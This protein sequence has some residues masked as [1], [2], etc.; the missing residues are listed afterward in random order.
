MSEPPLQQA[1]EY[2]RSLISP[3]ASFLIL[4]RVVSNLGD[5][6]YLFAIPWLVF[7]LTKSAWD[8]S[9]M[10]VLDGLPY[11]F[12]GAVAG[13]LADTVSKRALLMVCVI[14]QALLVCLLPLSFWLHMNDLWIVFM[15]GLLTSSFGFTFSVTYESLIPIMSHSDS[16]TAVT[17]R[18]K[19]YSQVARVVGPGLAGVI[20]GI[21]GVMNIL[22]L[23]AVSFVILL[24]GLLSI[25]DWADRGKRKDKSKTM[26]ARDVLKFIWSERP[27]RVSVMLAMLEN[28]GLALSVPLIVLYV[29]TQFHVGADMTGAVMTV[30]GLAAI[31]GSY[32]PVISEKT[33]LSAGSQIMFSMLFITLGYSVMS[34]A[35]SYVSFIAG[36]ALQSL[37]AMWF[38][39]LATRI[40]QQFSP[41]DKLGSVTSLSFSIARVTTPPA[42]LLGGIIATAVNIHIVFSITAIISLLSLFFSIS[43]FNI[44]LESPSKSLGGKPL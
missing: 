3:T 40:R 42:M 21:I 15:V 12:L 22:L 33:G 27:I 7:T 34:V 11:V 6:F 2:R 29:P 31:G 17:S 28:T 36:F 44:K 43:I 5:Q 39:I 19:R 1:S 35:P 13:R 24:V 38:S 9:L 20:V 32:M 41:K 4:S 30:A 37:G 14:G 23:D 16:L 25:R 8:M 10:R 26:K 18:I